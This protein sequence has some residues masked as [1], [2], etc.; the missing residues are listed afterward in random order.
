LLAHIPPG[1]IKALTIQQDFVT[2]KLFE[3]S[4]F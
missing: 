3:E 1:A 4:A 2:E